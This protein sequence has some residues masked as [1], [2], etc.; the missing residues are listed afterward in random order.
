MFSSSSGNNNLL[1]YYSIFLVVFIFAVFYFDYSNI[2]TENRPKYFLY[3][4]FGV[5]LLSLIFLIR[6]REHQIIT[7]SDGF[8]FIN[9]KNEKSKINFKLPCNEIK[10]FETKFNEIVFYANN[11]EKFSVK[12]DGI[13]SDK[14]RW[15]IK[16]L[17]RQHV[18]EN[19][20][21]RNIFDQEQ[22]QYLGLES[23]SAL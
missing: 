4:F 3:C 1:K 23:K 9:N 2:I 16:E 6:K 8:L 15:E 19:K 20:H 14:K 5:T 22:F 17:L 10:F 11:N 18:P 21:H 12:L 13:K 7:I